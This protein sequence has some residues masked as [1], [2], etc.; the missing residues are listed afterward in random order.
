MYIEYAWINYVLA[1]DTLGGDWGVKVG[2][3]KNPVFHE[4]EATADNSLLLVERSM[5]DNL[6]GGN[7]LAGPYVEGLNLQY[8]GKDNPLHTQ[9]TFSDGDGS[10]G[11]NFTDVTSA[12]PALL[13]APSTVTT[14]KFG[15]SYRVD[16]KFFGDWVD[17]T[18]A[19]GKNSGKTDF[20]AVGAGLAF[21]QSDTAVSTVTGT[22]SPIALTTTTVHTGTNVLRWDADGTY[23]ASKQFIIYGS[24]SGDYEEFRGAV[25]G[26]NER[27]DLAELL[28]AGY[29]L[30]PAWEL[31]ARGS[32]VESDDH[33][34]TGGESTFDE[35]GVG[36][37]YFLGDQGD[38]GNHAKIAGDINY[39]TNGTPGIAGLGYQAQAGARGEVVA[40]LMFQIW[41]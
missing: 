34:K 20:L 8:T 26:R 25:A 7:S 37:N 21:D 14:D 27:T 2:Q 32:L 39:L 30:D 13:G 40:R 35:L 23:L 29:F 31:T 33:F 36:L 12:S 16:Y 18:D 24:F 5:A 1:H 15:A 19:T 9:T 17:N 6:A 22:G 3:F 41:L 4:E 28:Q 38:A 10:Q 11:T